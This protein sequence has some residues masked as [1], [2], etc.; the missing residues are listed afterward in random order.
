MVNYKESKCPLV[1]H[2]CNEYERI[3]KKLTRKCREAD[4]IELSNKMLGELC[5]SMKMSLFER[6]IELQEIKSELLGVVKERKKLQA[7]NSKLSSENEMFALEMEEEMS[8]DIGDDLRKIGG[9]FDFRYDVTIIKLF[10][11]GL[12]LKQVEGVL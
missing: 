11:L 10:V 7:L 5:E 9:R 12:S 2:V 1:S 6:N 3:L 8:G 4:A